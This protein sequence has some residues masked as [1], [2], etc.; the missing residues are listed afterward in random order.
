[1][2][3]TLAINVAKYRKP[4]KQTNNGIKVTNVYFVAGEKVSAEDLGGA[5]LHCSQ[6]GVTDHFAV[7]DM[8]AV[9]IAKSIV[10]NLN[11]RKEVDVCIEPSEVSVARCYLI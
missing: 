4:I 11:Y 2:P 5:D 10:G 9:H 1:M 8:H 3:S 6:S 7:D